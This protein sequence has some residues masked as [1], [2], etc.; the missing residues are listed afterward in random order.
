MNVYRHS[1]KEVTVY[2]TRTT[3]DSG[4]RVERYFVTILALAGHAGW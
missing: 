1:L 3:F 2:I 4:R